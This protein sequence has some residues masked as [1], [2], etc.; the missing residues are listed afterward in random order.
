MKSIICALA[1]L[2]ATAALARPS[3]QWADEPAEIRQ[4]FQSVMQPENPYQSCC[5]EAD[6]FEVELTGDNPDGSIATKIIDGK[7]IIPNGTEI[8]VPRSKLQA[9]YGNPLDKY[10]LFIGSGGRIYCLIPKVGA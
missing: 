4:W 7:D 10:I 5:G 2:A 6:A 9:K 1:A 8:D 3:P